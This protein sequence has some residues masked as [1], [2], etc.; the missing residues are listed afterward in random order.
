M[1]EKICAQIAAS[2][3][4]TNRAEKQRPEMSQ[5]PPIRSRLLTL[6]LIFLDLMTKFEQSP[7]SS[8]YHS[9]SSVNSLRVATA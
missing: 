3:V 6:R 1:R 4:K 5:A 9:S 8:N 2:K 7:N